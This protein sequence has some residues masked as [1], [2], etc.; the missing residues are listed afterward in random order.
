MKIYSFF[1]NLFI[2]HEANDYKPH[3]F[4]E[5]SI[6]IILVLIIFLLGVSFGRYYFVNKTVLGSS[7]ITSVLVDLTNENRLAFNQA[8]LVR[9]GKL[10][11]AAYLKA[12]DMATHGYFAHDSPKGITP[13]HWFSLAG[14]KFLYAGENLAV[15]F[16]E[17][18]DIEQAWMDSPAHRANL[19]NVNFQ[20]IGL[21]TMEGF[22]DGNPT[23]FV[24]QMFGTPMKTLAL[25]KET[26]S[27]PK[28][29][30]STNKTSTTTEEKK[31]TETKSVMKAEV[32]TT[33]EIT[34]VGAV[35]GEASSTAP[36]VKPIIQVGGF[37]V[38]QNLEEGTPV[39]EKNKTLVT[40]STWFDRL[41]FSG[42]KYI[43]LIYLVLLIVIVIALLVMLVVEI[44]RQHWKH[45]S[46]GVLII[47]ILLAFMYINAHF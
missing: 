2:P 29:S 19:L 15:D 1:K 9:S 26:I 36:Q 28:V 6:K 16:T 39:L 32:Y 37:T 21:A 42:S 8:P 41:L 4:R 33:T 18:K 45:I 5:L 17:T 20:E 24:V 38:V 11:Q 3:F 44:R 10:D 22:Y 25:N 7:I 46:Y 47:I 35:K 43:S 30:T 14:Y 12:E 31:T 34:E 13:W 40:Y 23:I 27:T